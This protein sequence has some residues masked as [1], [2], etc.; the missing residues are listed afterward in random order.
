MA[1]DTS[2]PVGDLVTERPARAE[3]L[4]ELG[5]DYC[6]RGRRT[7]A[8]A[9]TAEGLDPLVIARALEDHDE[10]TRSAAAPGWVRLAPG[11]LC[12]HIELHHHTYVRD[13]LPLIDRLAAAAVAEDGDGELAEV[14]RLVARL[15]AELLPHLA[16]E[17]QALFPRIRAG[18]P[19]DGQ[20]MATLEA[21]HDLTGELLAAL[22]RTTAGYCLGEDAGAARSALYD[23]LA[24][25][26]DD[27]RLH[28]H[29]ETNVLFVA[30]EAER[31]LT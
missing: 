5:I 26:D 28:V 27:L 12:D 19:I 31:H 23:A 16:V 10:H 6:C 11:D 29:K 8:E 21:C 2:A 20:T 4:D 15:E 17:E 30:V 18:L 22:T 14:C 9:C 7:L 3:L 1:I 25:L 24:E 13:A